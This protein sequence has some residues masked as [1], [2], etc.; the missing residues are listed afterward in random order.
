MS[1]E[2]SFV[3][4]GR[5]SQFPRPGK[6]SHQGVTYSFLLEMCKMCAGV[7]QEEV[8]QGVVKPLNTT[9]FNDQEW[10]FQQK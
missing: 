2:V 4:A 1:L 8:L 7:Y 10:F 5:S 3:G 6:F 9:L